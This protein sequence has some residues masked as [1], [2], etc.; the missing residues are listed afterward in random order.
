M[1][2]TIKKSQWLT[3]CILLILTVG[4]SKD[5]NEPTPGNGEIE[6]SNGIAADDLENYGGDLGIIINTRDLA[7]KGYNP[8]KVK[9][10]TAATEGNYNQELDVDPF[11]NIAQLKLSV[12]NLLESAAQ[13]LK[14]G[15]GLDFEVLDGANNVII[16]ESFS[17]ISFDEGGNELNVNASAL[18]YQEEQFYFK[19]NMRYYLQLVNSSGSYSN[20]L[21][22]VYAPNSWIRYRVT[23][24]FQQQTTDEQ[25][26]ILKDPNN[27]D[28]FSF[29]SAYDNAYLFIGANETSLPRTLKRSFSVYYPSTTPESLSDS[30]KF[31]I[32]KESN[33]LY[34][35]WSEVANKPLRY[36]TNASNDNT[37]NWHANDS[38][39][40]QYFRIIAL[41]ISWET[42]E[43]STEYLQPLLP[44]ANTSFGFNSTLRNCGSG[45]LE[46]QVGIER[47]VTTTFTSGYLETVGLSGRTTTSVDLT[48]GATAEASFFGAG[49]SVSA[50]VSAGLEVSVEAS[51]ES[52]TSSEESVSETNTYFSNR[53]VTVPA[54][55]ASLVYDA[56]Q[57][58]SNVK[59]PYVKR[60]RLKGLH[61]ESSEYLTGQEIVTQLRMTNFSGVITNIGSDFVEV[62]I[63]GNM[64]LDNIVDTQTE[65]R[66]V[67][68]NCN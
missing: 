22:A 47:S 18:D 9:I 67:A 30:W 32:K 41:D 46:Q 10:T 23:D 43:L 57:T 20:T 16:S 42:T 65:V 24:N 3:M 45:S 27:P 62:S 51:T 53:T 17:V 58:Y 26:Y 11:T 35:I 21:A 64:Y 34:T 36:F 12:D 50:E 25:Y 61:T 68:A 29:Y 63:R 56:Y 40:L 49:G 33:G 44:K 39:G 1:K 66:D 28:L 13:E 37:T 8:V 6:Q 59:V 14:N 55:S 60:L 5:D 38:G 52:T 19:D 48:V 7:K 54:G 15:V 31:R 2:T 4:C